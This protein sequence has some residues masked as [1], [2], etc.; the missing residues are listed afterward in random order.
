MLQRWYFRFA[1]RWFWLVLIST[2]LVSLALVGWCAAYA[3]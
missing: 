2:W 3:F 1:Y